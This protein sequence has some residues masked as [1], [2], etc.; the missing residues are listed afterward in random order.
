MKTKQSIVFTLLV[1]F[2]AMLGACSKPEP[3]TA[4]TPYFATNGWGEGVAIVQHPAGEHKDGITY[5]SYQG[6]LED[7]YVAAYDHEKKE[8]LG[9][10]KAGTSTLGKD[11]KGKIDS[12]GKPTMI[13]DDLGY[14]H[15]FYGGHGGDKAIH[16]ENPFGNSALGENRH[17]VSKKP[18]DIT[19]WE[20]L[21]N[22][23]PFGTYNQAVKMDNG[24]LYLFYRHGAHRSDW[25]YQKSTDH[26]R[27]FEAPVPFLKH[28]RR[29]DGIGSDSWY[30]FA[31]KGLKDEIVVGF[32]YHYCWDQDAPRNNRGGH[33]TERKN[34][35]YMT[36]NTATKVWQNI[37][38]E[39]L[40]I[41][42]TKE[43]ADAKTLAVDTGEKWTFNGS[44]K[45]DAEGIPH[46]AAYIGEDIGWQIGGPKNARY[47]RWDGE[48]WA[49]NFENGLPIGRGDFLV[50]GKQIRFLLS[51]V[52]P[53]VDRTIVRWWESQDGGAS[54]A[55][56]K[57]LLRFGDYFEPESKNLYG[58]RPASLSNLDSPGSA[59]SAFIRNA[60]PDA[61]I[62]VAEK[63]DGTP[64]RRMY[65]V[66]DEGPIRRRT[67]D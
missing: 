25:V 15:I 62:I 31:T 43:E 3:E 60:H 24:D 53:S 42:L 21:N 26:G 13:I 64:Y 59:A 8:W 30:A 67:Q 58:D 50:S 57:E 22:I 63:P 20:D 7:P 61:R 46:I 37:H 17:S 29:A 66:G 41:P 38:D 35:Y 48:N 23:S 2:G 27:T 39:P 51:G 47:F 34:L 45:V 52:D 19:E 44:T 9:P 54:F 32:D 56:G 18:L 12:H 28:K 55:P 40:N 1:A 10:F 4:T 49:G 6:L 5:V 14:I 36:F 11:P 65:L 16:G 33:S